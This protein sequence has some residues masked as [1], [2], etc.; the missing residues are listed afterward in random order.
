MMRTV[1]LLARCPRCQNTFEA[2][3]PGLT[4]C[5]HCAAQVFVP[6]EGAQP[7][8]RGAGAPAAA[9]PGEERLAPFDE[10]AR[11]GFFSALGQTLKLA[12]L[13]PGALF[14]RLAPRPF[15]SALLFGVLVGGVGFAIDGLLSA[16]SP[17][18]MEKFL[19]LAEKL[20]VPIPRE[21]LP[22]A[23]QW[24]GYAASL[25]VGAPFAALVWMLVLAAWTHLLLLAFARPRH[26][27]EATLRAVGFAM[28]PLL[29]HAIP[30]CGGPV[31][32]LWSLGLTVYGVARMQGVGMGAVAAAVLAP[33]F[34]CCCGVSG[35]VLGLG[36]L[37]GL[38]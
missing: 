8:P 24:G 37:M 12:L 10:R 31:G 29:L 20:G 33:I 5:P 6:G 23:S 3:Q 32:S 17:P 19:A 7:P 9:L 1:P 35:V 27:F 18:D 26:P 4:A 13:D 36:K 14:D 21:S 28:A 38:W 15:G 25:V 11:L 34:L 2:A 16:S 30:S 22:D